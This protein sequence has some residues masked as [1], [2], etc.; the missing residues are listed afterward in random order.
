MAR[1]V[2][3]L[4]TA[5]LAHYC[6]P[7]RL[8]HVWAGESLSLTFPVG[9]RYECGCG[10]SWIATVIPASVGPYVAVCEGV[11]WL[12]ESRRQRRRRLGLRWWQR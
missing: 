9:T 3:V 6:R 12:P 5:P 7:P 11:E 4:P 10:R 8:E 1:V 2:I